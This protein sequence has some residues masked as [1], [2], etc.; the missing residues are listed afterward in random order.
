MHFIILDD[1]QGGDAGVPQ[2]ANPG[3]AI[4][5]VAYGDGLTIAS[6]LEHRDVRVRFPDYPSLSM[7]VLLSNHSCSILGF[8]LCES[9]L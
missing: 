9:P 8:E 5:C 2:G 6:W 4:P 1:I 3:V 7:R